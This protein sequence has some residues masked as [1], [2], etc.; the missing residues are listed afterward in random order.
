MIADENELRLKDGQYTHIG[1]KNFQCSFCPKTMRTVCDIRRHV[2]SLHL[3]RRPYTCTECGMKF[4]HKNHGYNHVRVV[5]VGA[6]NFECIICGKGQFYNF[7]SLKSHFKSL[8]HRR[9][10]GSLR[11]DEDNIDAENKKID[12]KANNM[13]VINMFRKLLIILFFF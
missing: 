1:P 4:S 13:F 9:M 8:T 7:S 5:H 2:L 10:Q 11:T 12:C 6:R 3:G